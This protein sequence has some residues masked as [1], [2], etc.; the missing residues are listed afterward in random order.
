MP[1]II[2]P[3]TEADQQ[4]IRNLVRRARL[5]PFGLDYR[6]F[7]VAEDHNRILGVG[8]IKSLRHKSRELASLVVLDEY[9]N[10]GIGTAIVNDLLSY[11]T[12]PIFLYCLDELQG[13]YEKFGFSIADRNQLPRTMGRMLILANIFGKL[14]SIIEGRTVKIIAMKRPVDELEDK[15]TGIEL[16]VN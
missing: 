6:R 4:I 14:A 9:Q 16:P 15:W 5:N 10:R 2:R 1:F 12:D 3:A 11:E 13:Y 8:Q 7:V